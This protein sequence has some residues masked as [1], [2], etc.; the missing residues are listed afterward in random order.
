MFNI[1][2]M[3]HSS[4]TLSPEEVAAGK[5]IKRFS[6]NHCHGILFKEKFMQLHQD[7][8]YF[9][10][11]HLDSKNDPVLAKYLQNRHRFAEFC[12]R[13]PDTGPETRKSLTFFFLGL[14]SS[15][16]MRTFAI[17]KESEGLYYR[18]L[19]KTVVCCRRDLESDA[20]PIQFHCLDNPILQSERPQHPVSSQKEANYLVT[21]LFNQRAIPWNYK[22]EGCQFRAVAACQLLEFMGVPQTSLLKVWAIGTLLFSKDTN[23]DL[24][25]RV[26]DWHIAPVVITKTGKKYVLDPSL[27]SKKALSVKKWLNAEESEI[28]AWGFSSI[29][30]LLPQPF[31]LYRFGILVNKAQNNPVAYQND[32]RSLL[33]DDQK[34]GT[35]T[36]YLNRFRGAVPY[37]SQLH[38]IISTD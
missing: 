25:D 5:K 38:K 31:E 34:T 37:N 22:R 28:T 18:A 35:E 2:L 9:Q 33:A 15:C 20:I 29:Q 19:P 30:D 3:S 7:F 8:S 21:V 16:A 10:T 26:W 14:K 36:M 23:I 4:R 1:A 6:V 11:H 24:E 27:N 13:H 32:V 12:L 17:K